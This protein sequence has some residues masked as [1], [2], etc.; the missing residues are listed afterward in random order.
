M[1]R[2][3][4]LIS[5]ILGFKR[6]FLRLFRHLQTVI[7]FLRAT[8]DQMKRLANCSSKTTLLCDGFKKLS[9]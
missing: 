7:V 5:E 3:S 8:N 6:E 1:L 4:R 2:I 9:C